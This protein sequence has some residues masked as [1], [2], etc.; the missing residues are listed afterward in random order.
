[1][2]DKNGRKYYAEF[3]PIFR[4]KFIKRLDKSG[5]GMYNTW[6][7]KAEQ[8]P[9]SPCCFGHDRVNKASDAVLCRTEKVLGTIFLFLNLGVHNY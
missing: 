5:K 1:M 3:V 8:S 6:E 9:F 2:I 7:N 4:K